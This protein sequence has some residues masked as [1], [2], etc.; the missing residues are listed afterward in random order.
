MLLSLMVYPEI[1]G[2]LVLAYAFRQLV[3]RPLPATPWSLALL[4]VGMGRSVAHAA[5]VQ[6]ASAERAVATYRA[7]Q[8]AFGVSQVAGSP[9]RTPRVLLYRDIYPSDPGARSAHLWPFS[10]AL[11]GTLDLAG[12]PAALLGGASYRAAVQDRLQGLARYW[13]AGAQPPGYASGV[14]AEGGGDRYYDD[15]AWVG[16]ALVQYARMGGDAA[17]LERAAEV[18]RFLASGWDRAQAAPYPGGVFWVE[19]PWNRD[20]GVVSN[21]PAA[22]LGFHLRELTGA[23]AFEDGADDAVGAAAMYDWVNRTLDSSGAGLGLYWDKVFGASG[24]IDQTLWSYN[25]GSMIAANLLRHRLA[26]A[27]DSPY[28]GRAESIAARALAQYAGDG[29]LTQDPPFNAVFFRALLALHARTADEALRADVLAAMQG[30]ADRAWDDP[31][32]R[33][34]ASGLFRFRGPG[35]PA[36]LEDQAAMLQ[37]YA[38]LAW[39]P[40]DYDRLA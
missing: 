20:R 5:G 13:Q 34:P 4:G 31:S 35:Q 38:L 9:V 12:V 16:L 27:S 23:T 3:V 24:Q 19:A 6:Q 29:Y 37:V 10:R 26:G 8:R 22:V 33:D 40:A 1:V 36:R 11:V 18:F 17:A 39:D 32:L 15:N 28:L 7:M 30:Y 14:V 25:Q 21:A 2:A